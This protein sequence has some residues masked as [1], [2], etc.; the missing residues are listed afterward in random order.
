MQHIRDLDEL[1]AT[2]QRLIDRAGECGYRLERA[3]IHTHVALD[4]VR[5]LLSALMESH[6]APLVVP[7]LHHLWMLGNP[8]QIREYLLH[9]GHQVLIAYEPAERTC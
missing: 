3:Y 1:L 2:H 5:G 8:L 9:S 4:T 7:T 6:G